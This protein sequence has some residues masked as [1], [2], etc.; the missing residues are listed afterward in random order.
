LRKKF[1]INCN[2][3]RV[4]DADELLASLLTEEANIEKLVVE[5]NETLKKAY[6]NSFQTQRA[7]RNSTSHRSV[8]RWSADLTILRKRTNAQGR[9]YQRTMN[10]DELREKRKQYFECKGT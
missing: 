9:L 3:S 5:F 6:N 7:P 2:T 4:E 1:K 10:N 8:S